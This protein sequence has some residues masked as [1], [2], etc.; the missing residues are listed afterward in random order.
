MTGAARPGQGRRPR[1]LS[2]IRPNASYR[3]P[4]LDGA[5]SGGPHADVVV[6]LDPRH[7]AGGCSPYL[8]WGADSARPVGPLPVRASAELTE[9]SCG[10]PARLAAGSS[11]GVR[12]PERP[13]GSAPLA[14][15]LPAVRSHSVRS[16]RA[17]GRRARRSAGSGSVSSA[18]GGSGSRHTLLKPRNEIVKAPRQDA[19]D[20]RFVDNV[21]RP[22]QRI[23][24]PEVLK[25]T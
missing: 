12:A 9:V 5:L 18:L 17:L 10:A 20:A 3:P 25:R 19:Q 2:T 1:W 15:S 23:S 11:R 6:N 13:R 21:R 7:G 8:S 4:R 24:P 16:G 22:W 14:V